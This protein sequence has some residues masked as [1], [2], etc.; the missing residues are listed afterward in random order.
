ML[1]KNSKRKKRFTLLLLLPLPLVPVLLILV[2]LVML[3]SS[4]IPKKARRLRAE[5]DKRARKDQSER[6]AAKKPPALKNKKT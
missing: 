2:L 1:G 4:Q 3:L 6:A 5:A